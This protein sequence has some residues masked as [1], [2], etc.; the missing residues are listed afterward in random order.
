MKANLVI[1]D[2]E[3]LSNLWNSIFTYGFIR[4]TITSDEV[5]VGLQAVCIYETY[6][7]RWYL[8]YDT[9]EHMNAAYNILSRDLKHIVA[10]EDGCD[11]KYIIDEE[12]LNDFIS[13]IVIDDED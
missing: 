7:D 4:Y 6:P 11:V 12:A 1:L 9:V 8:V 13:R 10:I 3:E 5:Q 2:G